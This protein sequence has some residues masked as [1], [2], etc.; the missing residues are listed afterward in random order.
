MKLFS[1]LALNMRDSFRDHLMSPLTP[2]TPVEN[3][4]L[5]TKLIIIRNVIANAYR[6][7]S[8]AETN[9]DRIFPL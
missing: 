6:V 7:A 3:L 5:G 2:S 4:I 1:I 9:W 8:R